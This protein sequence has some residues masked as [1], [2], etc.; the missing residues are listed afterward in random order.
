MAPPRSASGAPIEASGGTVS[1]PAGPG[2]RRW[3]GRRPLVAVV[4]ALMAALALLGAL[5]LGLTMT[6][7]GTVWLL[8]RVPA[9]VLAQSQGR[10]FGGPFAAERIEV[11]AGSRRIAIHG[12]AWRDARWTWRPHEG[13][14]FG[15]VID[16][17]RARRIEVGASTSSGALAPP[18]SLRLPFALTLDGLHVAQLAVEGRDV[19]TELAARVELGHERGSQ[20]RV[21]Q[22]TLHTARATLAGQL[23]I[24]ADAPFAL[25]AQLQARSSADA[26]RRWQAQAQAR[27]PLATIDLRAQLSSPEAAGAQ[28]DA[29]ATLSPFAA[30]PLSA[31]QASARDFDLAALRDGAPQTRLSGQARID[32]RGLDQP[33]AARVQV[34]NAIPGRWDAGRLPVTALELDVAGRVDQRDRLVVQRFAL[35]LPADGGRASGQGEWRGGQAHL[36]LTLQALRPATLD[37]RAPAMT[38]SGSLKAQFE[39]LPAPDG[40][41]PAADTLRARSQLALDGRLDRQRGTPARLRGEL[42][43][44][45][46]AGGSWRV[47]LDGVDVRAG[48]AQLRGRLQAQRDAGGPARLQSEGEAQGFDPSLWWAGA[49]PAQLHARWQAELQAPASTAWPPRDAASWLAL[50]GQAQLDLQPDSRL[51][52]V[53]LQG[54]L[55]LDGRQP[56]WSVDTE[57]RVAANRA[58]LQGHLAPRADDDRWQGEIDAPALAA[59]RPLL[60]ALGHSAGTEG[61]D[62]QLDAQL[63]L[64]GRW[65]TLRS[66]GRLR[67]QAVRAGAWSAQRLSAQ[68]RAG[69]DRDAP[70]ALTLEAARVAQGALALDTLRATAEGSL[71]SHR[72]VLDAGSTARPPAWTDQVLGQGGTTTGGSRVQLQAE[73]R[74]Q[75][76]G[77]SAA[78]SPLAGQW[79][80]RV[81]EFDARGRDAAQPWLAARDLRLQFTLDGQGRLAQAQAE[82]GRA[83]LLGA[84]VRWREA[85]YAA[86]GPTPHEQLSLDAELESLTIAP[87]LARWQPAA[88]FGGDLALKGRAIV[89]RAGAFEADLVLERA[90]GDLTITSDGVTQALGLTDLRLAMAASGGTWHFTQALA[91]ANMGVLAGAQTLRVAPTATWPASDTPM[92]GVLEW[93]VDDLGVWAPFTPPGWRVGGRLHT[94]AA[95]GGRFGAPEIEG[96]MEGSGLALRNILQGVDLREG[97]LALSLRGDEAR[98]ERFVFK[99]GDGQLTVTGGATLGA[100]PAATLKLVAQRFRVLGRAD[101][102][103]VASGEAALSLDAS[104]LAL[105]GKLAIDEGLIDVSRG[106]A[107]GLDDDVKV[108]GG[109]FA[110]RPPDAAAS[111]AAAPPPRPASARRN[112]RVA[113]QLDLGRQLR[114]RGRGLDTRLA[115]T[116][117]VSAPGG[118]IALDGQVSAQDGTY[119]AYGQKLEIERGVVSF[120]GAA[121][122]PRLDILAVRPNLDV[123][124]GV[125]VAG[126]AQAPRVR[127]FSEPE[128]SDYDKLSWLVLGRASDGLGRADTAL[129]QRAALALLAG[130]NERPDAALLANLG[131]DEFSVRQDESGEVRET[132]VMLG[133][134]LSRRWYVGYERGVNA[135]TGT[136]QLIYRV[137]QR[138]TLRAQ[139]G[140]DNA[141]DAI[142]TWRWN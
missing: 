122:N 112:V 74:W 80:A 29:Q 66:E 43:A 83:T 1:G 111:A 11:Q 25:D 86:A 125:Q 121:E 4:L 68:W 46:G 17:P 106:D 72:L 91:G 33:M 20:H 101:R 109:R 95:L 22:A 7:R 90:G 52:G 59:L 120:V 126:T 10:L 38:L 141:L 55:R 51:G 49:P 76:A 108:H 138:F 127:L 16:R 42:L 79:Q 21:V 53:P 98:I 18:A 117:A 27:G 119:A 2:A 48:A 116:L 69:P 102:R 34:T 92:Q 13:A 124:V 100:Q 63:Q 3:P 129:L 105:D 137:A 35:Q 107:P 28:L 89:R 81:A 94:S 23:G 77:G 12:L 26:A 123:V 6:D 93:R 88:G 87:W 70:L 113:L 85:R 75:A 24:A 133:K 37:A 41:L 58:S 110:A 15:L 134:Q 65:P 30:W 71:A 96:R 97:D 114:L 50:R 56:G 57:L 104:S 128:M 103:L 54:K 136:W 44:Q 9:L 135:T 140:T 142:W 67:S 47:Q 82:P 99:G 14:W 139:S 132:V 73:G 62:G 32:T 115:G 36:D 40:S 19:A 31:L 84:A 78:A 8:A 45:R 60:V 39:G 5:L 130:E 131:L 118:R 61:L 64:Q